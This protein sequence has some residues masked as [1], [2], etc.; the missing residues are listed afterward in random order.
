VNFVDG[1]PYGVSLV[2]THD[3]IHDFDDPT[4]AALEH[5]ARRVVS[6]ADRLRDT[7]LRTR[8]AENVRNSLSFETAKPS[9]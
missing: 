3:N 9:P 5:M 8:H 1:N 7:Y 2:S 6:I 4:N